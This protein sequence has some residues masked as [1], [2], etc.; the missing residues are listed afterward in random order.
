MIDYNIRANKSFVK[1]ASNFIGP[2]SFNAP[3]HL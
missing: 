2:V 1:N 3:N